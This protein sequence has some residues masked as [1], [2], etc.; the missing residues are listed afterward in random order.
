MRYTYRGQGPIESVTLRQRTGGGDWTGIRRATYDYY[1]ADED[2][3]SFGDL[4]RVRIQDPEGE[5]WGDIDVHYYRYYKQGDPNGFQHGLK[6]VL[7]PEPY[8]RMIEDVT[9]DNLDRAIKTERF[10]TTSSGN[11]VSRQETL[12]DNRGHVYRTIHWAVD[13]STPKPQASTT[14]RSSNRPRRNTT[15]RRT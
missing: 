2:F 14:T 7:G 13:V 8:A 4:K 15:Q 11:L 10:D 6:F 12:I 9:Y 1:G 3:G 5:G